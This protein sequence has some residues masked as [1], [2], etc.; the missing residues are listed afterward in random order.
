MKKQL[1]LT[2]DLEEYFHAAN[3]A[4]VCPYRSWSKLPSRLEF[5][6]NLILDLF[7]NYNQKGTF[8]VLGYCARKLPSLVKEIQNR[9]H[10][11]ASHGFSHK[12]AYLQS[13]K[14]FFRDI[15]RSKKLLEDITGTE[16]LGYRAPNFSIRDEN[17][18]A[19]DELTKA[20][21]RYDSSLYPVVHDRYRNPHRSMLPEL[22]STAHGAILILPL[23]V[24]LMKIG[25]LP[26]FRFPVAGGA[27]WRF[28]PKYLMRKGLES[29]HNFRRPVIC[30]MHPWELDE[31]QPHFANLSLERKIRHYFGIKNFYKT[32]SYFM[33]HFDFRTINDLI[34][35]ELF[36]GI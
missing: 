10:E 32:T 13:R 1:A 6:T 29:T 25:P 22:R 7:D 12:I 36:P 17:L 19:Y 20:G 16:I 34:D 8:F 18:W 21:Y 23:A 2:I 26:E 33:D 30:Y 14:Q 15:D 35:K 4:K 3:L 9:G 28:F 31:G 5:S 27:Y 24:S 11:V